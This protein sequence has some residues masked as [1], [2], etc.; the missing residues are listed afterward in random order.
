[1]DFTMFY[2]VNDKILMEGAIGE[3]LK[4]EFGITYDPEGVAMANLVKD[5]AGRDALTALFNDYISVAEEYD[6][7]LL[8]MT[9]T[10]RANK[11]RIHDSI[12]DSNLLEDNV[13]FLRDLCESSD[14]NVYLGGLMGCKGDAYS[15]LDGLTTEEG[16]DFHKWQADRFCESGVDYL[17]AGIMPS[18][19][20][21]IGMARAMA[22]TGLPYIISFMLG[23]D[24]CLIDGT[25]LDDAIRLIDTEDFHQ[26]VCYM[27]NCIHPT[28]LSTTLSKSFNRTERVKKRF[29]GVQ[30][31][32]SPLSPEELDGCDQVC[33]STADDL[34]N[35][36]ETL[37]DFI[38]LKIVGGCC[39]TT[40]DHIEE[41]AKRL[42]SR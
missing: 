27:S 7:P 3:R 33:S 17:Y 22:S 31:N 38:D 9:P 16:Y 10:R 11:E 26:P 24:G 20:E 8:I 35:G 32:S 39:G 13:H 14:A 30:V 21:A 28:R 15:A 2:D 19:D 40:K 23:D 6:L 37:N 1:M 5:K 25:T 42:S 12:Y 34:A 4:N 29:R 41:F 36:V 18:I